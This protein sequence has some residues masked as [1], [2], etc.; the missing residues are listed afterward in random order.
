MG[1][2]A[3][4]LDY[5]STTALALNG[6]SIEDAAGHAAVLT[7]PTIGTDGLATQNLKID[8]TPTVNVTEAGG[9]A[10][11]AFSAMATVAGINGSA[12]STLEGVTPTL[13]YYTGNSAM[14]TGS[15]HCTHRRGNV[16][17]GSVLRR[18]GQA[19]RRQRA[20]P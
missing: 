6:G 5:A 17:G 4:D 18:S 20:R 8:T 1:N 11:A 12:G 2:N 9:P 13:L 19:T 10:M 15:A 16:H 3:S 14:G 7:L